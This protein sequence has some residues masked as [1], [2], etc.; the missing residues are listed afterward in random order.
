MTP[1]T[2]REAERGVHLFWALVLIL[3]AYG[4]MPSWGE[5][6]IRWVVIPGV[7][8]SGFAMWFAAPLR[9]LARRARAR[10]LSEADT[11]IRVKQHLDLERELVPAIVPVAD[12]GREQAEEDHESE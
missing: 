11:S 5:Q 8:A 12:P 7:V 10:A 6:A 1:R 2:M 9:R 3:Y 4:L